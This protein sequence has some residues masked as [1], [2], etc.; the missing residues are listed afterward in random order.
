ME[1]LNANTTPNKSNQLRNVITVKV[2]GLKILI[3]AKNI[4]A[5]VFMGHP[6]SDGALNGKWY[7]Q[8]ATSSGTKVRTL[9]TKVKVAT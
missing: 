7:R 6:P 5:Q 9:V 1:I 4:R 8:G 3:E 2:T